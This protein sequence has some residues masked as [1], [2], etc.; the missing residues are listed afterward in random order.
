MGQNTFSAIIR[1]SVTNEPLAG[2]IAVIRTLG[3]GAATDMNGKVI[4]RNIP[5]GPQ[6]CIRFGNNICCRFV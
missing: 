1:D 5:D 4:L 2:A 6:G 3:N